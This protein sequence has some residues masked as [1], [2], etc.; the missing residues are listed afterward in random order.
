MNALLKLAQ[1]MAGYLDGT[2]AKD[3]PEENRGMGAVSLKHNPY[4]DQWIGRADWSDGSFL[5]T[6]EDNAEKAIYELI[7]RIVEERI[8]ILKKKCQKVS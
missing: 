5:E 7:H 3:N 2:P 1:D 4:T 6:L 8:D